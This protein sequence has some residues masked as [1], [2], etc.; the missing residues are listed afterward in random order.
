MAVKM[1][2]RAAGVAVGAHS[3]SSGLPGLRGG[4][5]GGVLWLTS[6]QPSGR[7]VF[8]GHGEEDGDV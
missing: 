7:C 2:G 3:S 6:T 1:F 4:G 5:G 8:G